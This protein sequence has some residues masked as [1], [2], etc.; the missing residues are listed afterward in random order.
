MTNYNNIILTDSAANRITQIT[1]D[2]SNK[3]YKKTLKVTI[4]TGGCAGLKYKYEFVDKAEPEDILI[5]NGDAQVAIDDFSAQLMEGATLDYVETSDC[6]TASFKID[7]P[8]SCNRCSCGN[9]FAV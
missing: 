7:N 3:N 5:K 6:G 8:S 9:S 1:T 4:H 2:P